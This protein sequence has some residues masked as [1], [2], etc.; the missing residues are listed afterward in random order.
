[1]P[2]SVVRLAIPVLL[3][4]VCALA[5]AAQAQPAPATLPAL[6]TILARHLE[7]RGGADRLR[8]VNAIRMTGTMTGPTG[9][10]VPTVVLMKRPD[11]IRQE[12]EV[13]GQTLVQAF[14]G[15]RGWTFN[16]MMGGAPV[17]VPRSIARR[18]ADQADFDG[19]LVNP[20]AKGHRVEVIGEDRVD[21]RPAVKL[22]LTKKSGEVQVV[23]LDRARWLEVKS[24]GTI[25][26]AGRSI[27]IESRHSD[28][29]SVDGITTPF[30]V[31]VFADGR[32]QQKIVIETMEF[33]PD[34]E[35]TL[36]QVPAR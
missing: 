11:R 10:Q 29:R 28:F 6:D 1:M 4:A 19:P 33:P 7:A 22:K 26:Q 34:L 2:A 31:E 16:P 9:E 20:A 21:D 5:P 36:F 24:E 13:D 3:A 12:I 15:S 17:E 27:Q 18:M 23:W 25:E 30:V 14:D 8:A 35:D 32:L